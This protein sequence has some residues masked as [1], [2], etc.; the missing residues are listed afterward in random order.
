MSKR[1]KVIRKK[2][3]VEILLA[4]F[5]KKKSVPL[6]RVI[7]GSQDL[8]PSEVWTE[9]S[10][11][12]DLISTPIC[13]SPHAQFLR[14]MAANPNDLNDNS[15]LS[16]TPYFAFIQNCIRV[17]GEYMGCV[18]ND[19][20]MQ[21][22]REFYQL[23]VYHRDKTEKPT[24]SKEFGHSKPKDAIV[25]AKLKKSDCYEILDGHHRA[26]IA[27][28][29][30]QETID[31]VV[32]KKKYS[33]LQKLLM[34]VNQVHKLPE[35]YQPVDRLEVKEWHALRQCE[36]RF[37]MANDYLEK[38]RIELNNMIDLACSYGWFPTAFKKK[39]LR[40]KG[41][42][43]DP[44]ALKIAQL[45]NGLTDDEVL[46]D[47]IEN[48][49]EQT[50]EKFDL[51][52]FLS[53]LHHYALGREPG[54]AIQIL[55]KV[56]AITNKVM[57]FDTGQNHERWFMRTL[58]KWDDQYIIDFIKEHTDF[59]EVIAL[60]KDKDNVGPYSKNYARTLFICVK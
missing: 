33:A 50:E 2:H 32:A 43:R 42:D 38:N 59:K 9:L 19:E 25:V 22:M 48:F 18:S 12:Y 51:V 56:A 57:L 7:M 5:K 3:L 4:Q 8:Y 23:F 20:V 60:G 29:L 52:V 47:R 37:Q 27:C 34:Q 45:I 54:E 17:S 28:V 30:G 1:K 31:V 53:I 40:V 46:C 24:F 16:N 58:R 13:D 44:N 15:I 10:G 14:Q 36:D 41:V 26:A 6:N 49:L 55:K 11:T 21:W 39:G 35:L